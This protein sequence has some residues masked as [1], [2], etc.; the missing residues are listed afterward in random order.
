MIIA[1]FS[2]LLGAIW[3]KIEFKKL[4]EIDKQHNLIYEVIRLEKLLLFQINS[5]LVPS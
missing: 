3:S 5:R 2:L 1:S 4:M